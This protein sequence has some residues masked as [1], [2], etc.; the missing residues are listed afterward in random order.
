MMFPKARKKNYPMIT[1]KDNETVKHAAKL[2]KSASYRR[3]CGQ[4]AAEGVRICRDGVRSGFSPELF[5]YTSAAVEKH[6]E[7]YAEIADSSRKVCEVSREVFSKICDT[8]SPQVFFCVYNM[9]DKQKFPYR[10]NKRGNYLA[11]ERIQDPSNLGTILRTAEA[12]GIEG[13]VL[14]EDCCDFYSPK[15]VRGSMGAVFRMPLLVTDSFVG[16]I[17]GLTES[18]VDTYASV[19]VMAE[20]ITKISFNGGVM[21]IG[22]EGNGLSDA[23]V[24]ACSKKITI[25]MRGRAESLNAAA[26]AAVLMWEMLRENSSM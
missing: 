11:L 20:D 1:S 10:I 7:D 4:F 21:L 12:L 17:S 2:V 16:Y 23:A 15:V 13:A 6:P 3:E 19:P 14:S 9:L 22:N 25:P 26:A 8:K 5:L 24:S 18:G